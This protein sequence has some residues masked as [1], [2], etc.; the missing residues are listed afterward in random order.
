MACPQCRTE[1]PP[2][3]QFCPT[4]GLKLAAVC[5]RCGA[6]NAPSHGF[7]KA[8]G[9]RLA[10]PPADTA[11][12]AGPSREP[13]DASGPPLVLVADDEPLIR[14][15]VSDVL[16]E[17]GFRTVRAA[18]GSEVLPLAL[19]HR[20]AL[21]VMDVMMPNLDGYTTIT[22]LR[23]HV[24]TKDIPVVI[25]TGQAGSIYRTLSF[26]LGATAHLTKPFSPRQLMDVVEGVLQNRSA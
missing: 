3:A 14:D 13:S 2:D 7:C 9:L 1:A 16:A 10:S 12:P 17:A 21:I 4:C 18:D 5:P 11:V 6:R 8:C 25:L 26:G 23:N 22:R 15:L 19:E 20:P 24:A